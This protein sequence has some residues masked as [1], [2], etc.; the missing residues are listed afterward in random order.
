ME[1]RCGDQ[2]IDVFLPRTTGLAGLRVSSHLLAWVSLEALESLASY[3]TGFW[4]PFLSLSEVWLK[5]ETF[6]A[7]S[8]RPNIRRGPAERRKADDGHDPGSDFSLHLNG[9]RSPHPGRRETLSLSLSQKGLE[10]LAPSAS[11]KSP[12]KNRSNSGSAGPVVFHNR[13]P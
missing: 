7:F 9:T 4:R 3:T 8:R 10:A 5:G 13:S 2:Q 1:C 11:K 6:S 12:K